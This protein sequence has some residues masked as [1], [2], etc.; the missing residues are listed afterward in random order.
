[1]IR[2][3]VAGLA[4]V[5]DTFC[6]ATGSSTMLVLLLTPSKCNIKTVDASD[7]NAMVGAVKFPVFLATLLKRKSSM[8]PFHGLALSP[9]QK[10]S[11]LFTFDVAVVLASSVPL[12]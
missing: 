8:F 1:M 9:I 10:G 11:V 2:V 6:V 12:M 4:P 3:A 7:V 5:L